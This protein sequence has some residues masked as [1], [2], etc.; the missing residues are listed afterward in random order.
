MRGSTHCMH[1]SPRIAVIALFAAA[2]ASCQ[3]PGKSEPT[4][5][6]QQAANACSEAVETYV[7]ADGGNWRLEGTR[8]D[9]SRYYGDVTF[10]AEDGL[11]GM[12]LFE[13]GDT[14]RPFRNVKAADGTL[15]FS[16]ETSWRGKR[17]GTRTIKAQLE[18]T[19]YGQ[20]GGR[21]S[22]P[23]SSGEG[24]FLDFVTLKRSA[25]AR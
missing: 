11:E 10:L 7:V 3:A 25:E 12:V 13:G 23:S 1:L 19:R 6:Q 21:L 14:E 9:G 4:P 8:S 18:C 17:S 24:T 15:S 5:E 2:T 22:G 20:L 16:F